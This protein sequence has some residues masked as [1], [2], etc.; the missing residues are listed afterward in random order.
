MDTEAI[1]NNIFDCRKQEH[2]ADF[3]RL[4]NRVAGYIRLEG[5]KE[6]VLVASGIETFT[7]PNTEMPPLPPSVE[8]PGNPGVLIK[9]NRA[10][11]MWEELRHFQCKEIAC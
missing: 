6:N 9:D 4:L 5:D 2:A 10:K 1:K 8:D 11:I 7:I 3:E